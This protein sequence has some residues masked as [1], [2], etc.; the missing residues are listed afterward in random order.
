MLLLNT[1]VYISFQIRVFSVY[2]PKSGI[3]RSYGNSAFSFLRNL[4]T[5]FHSVYTNLHSHKQ[6]WRV[7]FSPQFLQHLL[8]IDF[9]FFFFYLILIVLGLC[10][11]TPAFYSC[12]RTERKVK[13]LSCVWLLA[14]PWTITYQALLSMGFSRQEYW[15]GLPFPSPGIYRL[16]NDGH[17]D[18]Y[19]VVP[20]C[21]FICI[22]LIIGNVEH[23]L[24]CLLVVC[25]LE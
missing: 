7:P 25:T 20:H 4:H 14:T 8:F 19:E 17:S 11:C 21:S 2:M 24:I 12:S 13:S 9:F 15:S 16:L 23:L 5:V 1:A 10:C 3:A 22:F 6:Y 18:Q